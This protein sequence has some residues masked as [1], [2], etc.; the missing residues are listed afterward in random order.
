[1]AQERVPARFQPL[2]IS[3][4][5]TRRVAFILGPLVWLVAFL[6]V[7]VVVKR[8]DAVEL[9]LIV[10]VASFGV[11]VVAAVAMRRA[12]VRQEGGA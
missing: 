3:A 4:D 6:V 11:G 12:R 2:R 5:V 8:R 1:M 9:A 10:V 7:A